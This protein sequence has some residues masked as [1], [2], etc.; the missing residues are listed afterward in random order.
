MNALFCTLFSV[1][2]MQK[3][4]KSVKTGQSCSHMYTATFWEPRQNVGFEFS[5]NAGKCPSIA[6]IYVPSRKSGFPNAT[7]CQNFYEKLENGSFCA[8]VVNSVFSFATSL[9]KIK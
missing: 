1:S 2:A 7:A 3:L 6:K 5:K 8:C 4:L 9:V